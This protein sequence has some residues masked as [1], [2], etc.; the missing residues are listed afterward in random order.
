MFIQS[1]QNAS[2]KLINRSSFILNSIPEIIKQNLFYLYE[3]G[4]IKQSQNTKE[5]T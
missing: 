5:I 3:V 2:P 4:S 1:I